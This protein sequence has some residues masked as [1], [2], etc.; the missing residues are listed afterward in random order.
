MA[1]QQDPQL[2]AKNQPSFTSS[3]A[4]LAFTTSGWHNQPSK[5]YGNQQGCSPGLCTAILL[6]L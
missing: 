5:G 2:S 6:L 1:Y 3:E 4:P